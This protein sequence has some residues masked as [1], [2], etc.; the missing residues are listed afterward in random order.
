VTVYDCSVECG[1]RS[2][3]GQLA[4]IASGHSKLTDP[5]KSLHVIGPQRPLALAV[6]VAP[7]PVVWPDAKTMSLGVYAKAVARFYHFAGFVK[8]RALA[9]G[10]V[11]R[12]GGDWDGDLDFTDQTFDDCDHFELVTA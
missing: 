6:D 12:F 11:I 7:Y 5:F 3:E 8:A 2:V 4:A 10:I 9:L 1:A